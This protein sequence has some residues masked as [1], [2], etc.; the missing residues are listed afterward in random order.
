MALSSLEVTII[1]TQEQSNEVPKILKEISNEIKEIASYKIAETY[2]FAPVLDENTVKIIF[3]ISKAAA[4]TVASLILGSLLNKTAK[5]NM[6]TGY[7]ERLKLAKSAL[8]D[9]APL[10]CESMND[11]P[12]H[13]EYVFSTAYGRYKWVYDKGETSLRKVRAGAK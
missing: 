13:S 12:S 6:R 9:K 1:C 11:S 7:D 4:P 3:E 10:I 5:K 8:E 2:S